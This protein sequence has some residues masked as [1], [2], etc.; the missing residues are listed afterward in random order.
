MEQHSSFRPAWQ[1]RI[2]SLPHSRKALNKWLRE[3]IAALRGAQT[4][5]YLDD[6]SRVLRSVRLALDSL[7]DLFRASLVVRTVFSN[8]NFHMKVVQAH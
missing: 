1:D 2:L 4:L 6:M 5:A 8:G 7:A 3:P